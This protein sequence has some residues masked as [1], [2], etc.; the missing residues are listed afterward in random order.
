M[1]RKSDP[2]LRE[3][4]DNMCKMLASHTYTLNEGEDLNEVEDMR[5]HGTM[6]S[7]NA[8][9]LYKACAAGVR[10]QKY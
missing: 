10:R 3:E 7:V 9:N 5:I 6:Y 1:G 4:A 2:L 8:T